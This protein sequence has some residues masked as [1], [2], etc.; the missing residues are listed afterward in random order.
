M[1]HKKKYLVI[2]FKRAITTILES[3]VITQKNE[4]PIE[5]FKELILDPMNK[6]KVHKLVKQEVDSACR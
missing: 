6:I 3:G 5:A 1:P 4:D 2:E